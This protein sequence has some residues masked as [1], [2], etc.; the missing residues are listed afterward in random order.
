[1]HFSLK[2]LAAATALLAAGA[3]AQTWSRYD[4]V[5]TVNTNTVVDGASFAAGSQVTGQVFV[6]QGVSPGNGGWGYA[7][8][9]AVYTD[10]VQVFTFHHAALDV[11][12]VGAGNAQVDNNRRLTRSGGGWQDVFGASLLPEATTQFTP[13]LLGGGVTGLSFE[14]RSQ[15]AVNPQATTSLDLPSLVNVPLFN[16]T[17]NLALTF[18]NSG[19]VDATI[20]SMSVSTVSAVPEPG[21]FALAGL[22]LA[23]LSLLRRR[24]NRA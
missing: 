9:V 1:M 5:A 11:A 24:Q 15:F 23:G 17:N 18:A 2:T 20:Q 14:M 21:S 10:A 8:E 3:Q 19:R 13:T 16:S 4:Y 12:G 22:G 7:G 6:L